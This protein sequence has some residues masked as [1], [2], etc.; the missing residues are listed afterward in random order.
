MLKQVVSVLNFAAVEIILVP[1]ST[2]LILTFWY[3]LETLYALKVTLITV[4]CLYKL[5]YV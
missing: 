2:T 4:D 5:L 1:E 3:T